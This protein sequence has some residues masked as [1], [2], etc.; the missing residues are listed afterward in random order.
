MSMLAPVSHVGRS[1][2]APSKGFT[3]VELLVVIGIIAVLI[4]ILLPSLNGVRRQ[5]MQVQ[6]Q[7]NL[8]QIVQATGVYVSENNGTFQPAIQF[9]WDYGELTNWDSSN[10]DP[11]R[12]GKSRAGRDDFNNPATYWYPAAVRVPWPWDFVNPNGG[13]APSYLPEFFDNA[14]FLPSTPNPRNAPTGRPS[15]QATWPDVNPIWR[16]PEVRDGTAPLPWMVNPN[17]TH[18]R[19]NIAYAAGGKTSSATRSSVAVLYFDMC[20]SDWPAASYPHGRKDPGVNVAYVDGHVGF[21]TRKELQK[22][23]WTGS[24]PGYRSAFLSTGWRK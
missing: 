17:E 23:G 20:W 10:F 9:W 1:Q 5:A 7:S 15:V 22:A 8:K 4:S 19:F 11:Y 6:C 12:S 24:G 16:C 21:L 2:S 18:Y 3:L 13:S 14:K